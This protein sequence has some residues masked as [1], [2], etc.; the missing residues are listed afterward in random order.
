M[1][2]VFMAF[3]MIYLPALAWAI[4]PLGRTYTFVIPLIGTEFSSWRLYLL[5]IALLNGFVF[6]G[7][8]FLPESPKFL[9]SKNRKEES[10]AALRQ[11]YKFNG[12]ADQF[13]IDDL[14]ETETGSG[15]Q[16]ATNPVRIVWTQT[17]QL[18]RWEHVCNTFKAS[19]TMGGIFLASSGLYMWTPDILNKLIHSNTEYVTTCTAVNLALAAKNETVTNC[20][21]QDID[22]FP[23]IATLLMSIIFA[24]C[25][26]INGLVINKVGK[27]NLLGK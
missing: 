12:R 5:L 7:L 10:L 26:F 8:F 20:L 9:L 17:C 16:E 24:I 13:K 21:E 1:S 25:Y 11:M 22:T 27:K 15:K 18:F 6:V 4:I 19:Y 23:F 2:G 14:N 3:G